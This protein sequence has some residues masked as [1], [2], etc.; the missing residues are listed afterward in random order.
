[1]L[2]PE[3]DVFD[4]STVRTAAGRVGAVEADLAVAR[5]RMANEVQQVLTPEQLAEARAL[6]DRMRERADEWRGH[7]RWGRGGPA[8]PG[9]EGD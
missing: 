2:H 4:E 9:G 3:A 7:R 8:G 5:A 6:H 1:M